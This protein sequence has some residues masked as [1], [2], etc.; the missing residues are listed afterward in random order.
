[1]PHEFRSQARQH[2]LTLK[3][4]CY[5][6]LY[7]IREAYIRYSDIRGDCQSYPANSRN[8]PGFTRTFLIAP[9]ISLNKLFKIFRPLQLR[10]G[11]EA[12]MIVHEYP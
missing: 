11:L 2:T 9:K 3:T 5:V 12:S 1:M 8:V 7:N 6:R 10:L 4:L